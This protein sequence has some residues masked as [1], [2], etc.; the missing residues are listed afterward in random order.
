MED[1]KYEDY[2]LEERKSLLSSQSEQAKSFDKWILTLAGGSFGLSLIFV[3][4]I[5]PHPK[6]TGY[7]VTAWGFFTASILFTL[8]SFLLSQEAHHKYIEAVSKLINR[9]TA[10]ENKLPPTVYGRVTKAL[11]YGS[12]IVFLIGIVFLIVFA[13]LNLSSIQGG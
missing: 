9:E 7:L 5:A 4:Q 10:R 1:E 2:L 12:M 6:S 11:N 8:F 13:K 3:Y